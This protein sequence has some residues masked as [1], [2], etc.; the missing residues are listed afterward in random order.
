[1]EI[2][3]L[4]FERRGRM[5][6]GDLSVTG[7]LVET[8]GIDLPSPGTTMRVRL[9]SRD[10]EKRVETNVR[11]V[12]LERV[13]DESGSFVKR[14][15]FAFEPAD[16]QEREKIAM[17]FVHIASEQ[18][19]LEGKEVRRKSDPPRFAELKIDDGGSEVHSLSVETEWQL[20]KGEAVRIELPARRGGAVAYSGRAVR[21]RASKKGTYRTKIAFEG[22]GVPMETPVNAAAEAVP[23]NHLHGD[24]S[25][26]RAPSLLSLAAL[27]SMSGELVFH[28][29]K[30]TVNFYLSE[31][32]IVD[33]EE[34]GSSLSRRRLIAE[35][36]GW[37]EG[38]FDFTLGEVDR[39]DTIGVPTPALLLQLATLED[40]RRRVA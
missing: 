14:A 12:R 6:Q 2:T 26:I 37:S 1:M 11:V 25:H 5:R 22:E 7:M 17:L 28:Q 3:W 20:R 8:P 13:E 38:R 23:D 21:S 30:R 9:A 33:V 10:G 27:E 16:N 35:C 19:Q 32:R 40:E 34:E 31:G 24:L 18:I 39:E 36:C 15:G 29:R 4:G